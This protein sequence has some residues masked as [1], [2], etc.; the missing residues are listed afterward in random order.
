MERALSE[1]ITT[2]LRAAALVSALVIGGSVL[3][4]PEPDRTVN[5]LE[6]IES[7]R[8]DTVYVAPGMSL[9]NYGRVL[10]GG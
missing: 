3:R 6:R 8:V 7:R 2:Y 10:A 4:P 1:E 5:R 9:A